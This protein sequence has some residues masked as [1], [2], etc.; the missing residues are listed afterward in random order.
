MCSNDGH[1]EAIRVLFNPEVVSLER[2]L[3]VWA[4]LHN[5]F[6]TAW[7]PQYQSAVWWHSAE[8]EAVVRRMVARFEDAVETD[9]LNALAPP[10][11]RVQSLLAP[12]GAWWDA[13]E[14]HQK[15]VQKN[16]RF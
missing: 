5:P 4:S 8:Q 3:E 12:A 1:T 13:E 14:R 9:D 7:K 10:R 6:H 16:R 11:P 15:W 2:L